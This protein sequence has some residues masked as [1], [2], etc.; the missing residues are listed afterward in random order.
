MKKTLTFFAHAKTLVVGFCLAG[1]CILLSVQTASAQQSANGT[2]NPYSHIAEK[3]SVTAYPL[4]EFERH[5][6]M[7][8][9]ENILAGLK[10]AISN[11]QGSNYQKLKYD[12]CNAVLADITTRYVAVEISLLTS[13]SGL[14]ARQSRIGIQ[15]SQLQALYSD[16]V[17]QI[18]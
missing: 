15:N 18:Q 2:V 8:V 16:I 9:L 7:D 4:G 12:F 13:L 6:T 11:G 5:H 1:A 17:A 3:I 10:Q 14:N